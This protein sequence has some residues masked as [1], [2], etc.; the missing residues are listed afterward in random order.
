MIMA[1]D[2]KPIRLSDLQ[3][4]SDDNDRFICRKCH[5]RDWRVYYTREA[6]GG[7]NR[8]RICRNCGHR[9]NTVERPI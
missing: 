4:G 5:C 2:R 8:Q 7:V 1:T 9:M 3:R 6:I